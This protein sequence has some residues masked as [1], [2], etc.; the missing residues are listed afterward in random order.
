V[1]KFKNDEMQS[2]FWV[3]QVSLSPDSYQWI[4]KPERSCLRK[5][6]RMDTE[7]ASM[8]WF[9]NAKQSKC[10]LS[11]WE[12]GQAQEEVMHWRSQDLKLLLGSADLAAVSPG[13]LG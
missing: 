1:I 7:E 8:S 3:T 12:G 6:A 2:V 13:K 4:R 10:A 5:N 9:I 11:R